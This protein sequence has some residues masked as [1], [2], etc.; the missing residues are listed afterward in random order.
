[1]I[2]ACRSS[3]TVVLIVF[4]LSLAGSLA[5][6]TTP[7]GAVS[8]T[9]TTRAETPPA[10]LIRSPSA[11]VS[12]VTAAPE[13]TAL[14]SARR[15]AREAFGQGLALESQ[16][17]YAAAI[18]SYMNAARIDP[19][20]RGA[21]FRIGRL[22]ASRAQWDPAARAFREE[23][24]RNPNDRAAER[25]HALMLVELGDTTRPMRVL[26][27][28]TRRAP[29]DETI[30]RALGFV[31][32][33]LGLHEE[34]EKSLRGAVA[35]NAKY[36]LAWRDLGVVLVA[37]GR[38][39]EAREAYRRSIRLDPEDEGA[40]IN[41][42][43]LEA[44]AGDHERALSLYRDVERLD[45]LQAYAYRGQIRELVTLHREADAGAVWRRWLARVPTDAVV[46]EGA[47]RHF[48]RQ[49]RTDVALALAREG[50]RL[51][52]RQGEPWWLLGEMHALAGDTAAALSAYHDAG[53]RFEDPEGRAR[54]GASLA[55]LFA[56]APESLRAR[57]MADTTE[58][59]RADR[60]ARAR[61]DRA[62]QPRA[63]TT[64][65]PGR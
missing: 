27:A 13:D 16:R 33:R 11:G 61:A 18:M 6:S 58:Q 53:R 40:V 2:A 45:T 38:P 9:D 12:P 36:A 65:S 28:L 25:E 31:Q 35:L 20:L 52:P 42:A 62:A 4:S 56:V 24:R 32:S 63:D 54:A 49:R 39:A 60:A 5:V 41:L 57:F 30:W 51:L 37:R 15:R 22:Y 3:S 34:A 43:N 26:K 64:R 55:A 8:A 47:A 1:M 14:A 23:L 50:V 59:G 10:P 48:V 29:N 21:S 17:A 19:T 46:R 44:D 7:S